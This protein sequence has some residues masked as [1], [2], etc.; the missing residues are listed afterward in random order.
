[1]SSVAAVARQ[2]LRQAPKAAK[3]IQT[4]A[5]KSS[6]YGSD[7]H[8]LHAEHMYEPWNMTSRKVKFGV[9]CTAIVVGGFGIPFF[10]VWWQRSKSGV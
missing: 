6:G 3:S 9:G 10:A 1:M 2:A 8:Y 4:S 5:P 7:P